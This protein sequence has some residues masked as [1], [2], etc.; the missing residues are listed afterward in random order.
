MLEKGCLENRDRLNCD[1]SNRTEQ[2]S[3]VG[4]CIIWF[5]KGISIIHILIAV[6]LIS[7]TLRYLC[8]LE[9]DGF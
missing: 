3:Y 1:S 7:F 9:A 2:L 4:I 6:A 5:S 8:M